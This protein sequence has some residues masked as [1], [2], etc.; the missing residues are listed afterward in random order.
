MSP[1]LLFQEK[2]G[3]LMYGIVNLIITQVMALVGAVVIC[4]YGVEESDTLINELHDV[5][6]E[7]VYK[8]DIDPTSS[9]LLRQIMEYVSNFIFGMICMCNFFF[10]SLSLG[11]LLRCG[12]IR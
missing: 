4:V 5:F 9:R 12:R 8:W 6:I 11:W 3:F 1:L 2:T 7:L 10:F